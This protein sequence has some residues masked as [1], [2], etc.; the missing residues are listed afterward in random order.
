MRFA[1]ADLLPKLEDGILLA[2]FINILQPNT[3][4][5]RALSYD[6]SVGLAAFRA[7]DCLSRFHK[8]R[9]SRIGR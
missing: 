8:C 4:D 5:L 1:G 3:I 2:H 6:V 9:M 7:V